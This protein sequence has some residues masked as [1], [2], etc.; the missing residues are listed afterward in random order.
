MIIRT[1]KRAIGKES[2]R[3]QG[4][5]KPLLT[6]QKEFVLR[7]YARQPSSFLS[8]LSKPRFSEP[9]KTQQKKETETLANCLDLYRSA[10]DDQSWPKGAHFNKFAE[11]HHCNA[12]DT[13]KLWKQT[14]TKQREML[15]RTSHSVVNHE[16]P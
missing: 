8:V 10:V 7:V 15:H 2:R 13:N 9:P 6:I 12:L 1:Q 14:E 3:K 11:I 16:E 4:D 5:F